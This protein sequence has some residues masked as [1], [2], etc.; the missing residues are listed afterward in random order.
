MSIT[1]D[2]KAVGLAPL[3]SRL[4]SAPNET[5]AQM[6]AA[7]VTSTTLLEGAMRTLAPRDTGRLQGSISS[8]ISGGGASIT[9]K[10]GPSVRYGYWVEHGRAAGRQPPIAAISGWAKRHGANP[11]LM[12]R[13]IGRRGTRA[14]PFVEPTF[15]AN[16]GKVVDIFERIGVK[17]AVHIAG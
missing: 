13:G 6:R 9:G 16:R 1:L 2:V 10:V 4:N 12:A 11:F 7:M 8:E 15:R 3:Q 14:Q 17:V 5:H